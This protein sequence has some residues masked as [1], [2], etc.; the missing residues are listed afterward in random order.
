MDLDHERLELRRAEAH[1]ARTDERIRLQ[2][3]LLRELL[4]DGHDT[5]LAGLL[6]DELKET[7]RVMLAHHTLIVDQI[8]RLQAKD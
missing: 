2:E 7:R 5:T 3:D 6:L 8:A 1:I 4:Q